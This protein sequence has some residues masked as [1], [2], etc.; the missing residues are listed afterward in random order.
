MIVNQNLKFL[1]ADSIFFFGKPGYKI[2]VEKAVLVKVLESKLCQ[3]S[4]SP[5]I[6]QFSNR[7]ANLRSGT[8]M[9]L[10]SKFRRKDP[11][12]QRKILA[13][14]FYRDYSWIADPVDAHE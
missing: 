13:D 6:F 14:F 7:E 11:T 4:Y 8:G 2:Y 9:K 3:V 10:E 1:Y 5:V 12:N